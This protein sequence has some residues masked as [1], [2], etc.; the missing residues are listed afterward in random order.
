[1]EPFIDDVPEALAW[2]DFAVTC[3]GAVTLAEIV[4]VALPCLLVTL[5]SASEDHQSANA[6]AFAAT[7]GAHWVREGDWRPGDVVG[8]VARTLADIEAWRSPARGVHRLA[9][10]HAARDLVSDCEALLGLLRRRRR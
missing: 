1:L 6:E 10:P 9:R 7:S 8:H 4:C 2:A 5:S 3:P